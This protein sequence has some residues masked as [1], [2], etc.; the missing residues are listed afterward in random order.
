[1]FWKYT[2]FESKLALHN[3]KNWVIALF[4]LLIFTLLFMYT[5]NE[6]PPSSLYDQKVAEAKEL[7]ATF[8]HLDAVRFDDEQAAEVYDLVTQQ[9]SLI[10]MQRWYIGKGDDPEQYI[11][12]GLTVNELRLQVHELGNT[13]IPK[14]Y[15]KPKAEILKE[16][17]ILQFVKQ[18]DLSLDSD[19]FIPSDMIE[20]AFRTI[21]GLLFF[22]V[23]LITGSEMLTF[24]QRH[25]SIFNGIPIPFMQKIASKILIHFIWISICL[26]IGFFIGLIYVERQWGA[27]AFQFPVLIYLNGDYMAVSIAQYSVYMFLALFMITLIVLLGAILCNMLLKHAFA[28]ILTGVAVFLIPHLMILGGW[29]IPILSTIS[30]L[31]FAKILDGD[32]ATVVSPSMDFINGYLWMAFVLVILVGMIYTLHKRSYGRSRVKTL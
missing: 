26:I 13:G 31:D 30:Y 4:F 6:H 8:H 20:N 27:L 1:M 7:E 28:T 32:I 16:S 9:A 21:S 19:S 25:R 24:E 18:H 23:L 5:T 14:H 29:K 22:M 17:A 3:R 10:N 15:I 11:D 12:D 2:L